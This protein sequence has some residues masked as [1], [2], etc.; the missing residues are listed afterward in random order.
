MTQRAG[1]A[2]AATVKLPRRFFSLSLSTFVLFHLVR[3]WYILYGRTV[4]CS[5]SKLRRAEDKWPV[6]ADSSVRGAIRSGGE[7]FFLGIFSACVYEVRAVLGGGGGGA[8]D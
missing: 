4:H 2:E 3:S 5:S 7:L 6:D 8:R 1:R